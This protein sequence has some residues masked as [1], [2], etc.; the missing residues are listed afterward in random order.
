MLVLP[1]LERQRQVDLKFKA[2]LVYRARS[3]SARTPEKPSLKKTKQDVWMDKVHYPRQ[4]Q[5]RLG[6][7]VYALFLAACGRGGEGVSGYRVDSRPA[8]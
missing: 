3:R 7:E 5:K 1:A 4:A 6:L 2:S 8:I